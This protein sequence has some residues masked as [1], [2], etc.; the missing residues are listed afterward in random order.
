M[1]KKITQPVIS[2]AKEV[3]GTKVLYQFFGITVVKKILYTP[4]QYGIREWENYQI[5]I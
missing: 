2:S 5:V 3:V 4:L 1:I